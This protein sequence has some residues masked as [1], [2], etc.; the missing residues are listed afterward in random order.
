M[1]QIKYCEVCGKSNGVELHHIVFKSEC[2]PLEKCKYNFAYLCMEHHKGNYGPHG[3]Y[4]EKFNRQ[5][6]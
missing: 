6:K 5:L 1:K 4:G 3:K 2:K